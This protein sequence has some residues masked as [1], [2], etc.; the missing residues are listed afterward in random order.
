MKFLAKGQL[1]LDDLQGPAKR[2]QKA[3]SLEVV[4]TARMKLRPFLLCDAVRLKSEPSTPNPSLGRELMF[5]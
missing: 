1:V 4:S 2:G 3:E 5:L